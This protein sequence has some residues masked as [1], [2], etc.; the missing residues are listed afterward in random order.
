MKYK[1]FLN[2]VETNLKTKTLKIILELKISTS[3][4]STVVTLFFLNKL[5]VAPKI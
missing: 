5:I 2:F 3:A 4:I 1:C